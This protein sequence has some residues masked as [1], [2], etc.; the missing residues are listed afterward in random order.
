MPIL[1]NFRLFFIRR[2]GFRLTEDV[3]QTAKVAKVLLLLNAGK[4][5]ELKGKNLAEIQIED[6]ALD[7]EPN[8]ENDDIINKN[9]R[10][11]GEFDTIQQMIDTIEVNE[12][13]TN[14][15]TPGTSKTTI[16]DDLESPTEEV[17]PKNLPVKNKTSNRVRWLTKEKNAVL[18]Y[19]ARHVK[20]KI[21]PKKQECLEFV[22]QS[23]N[24]FN[25]TDWVRIKTLVFNTYRNQD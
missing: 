7:I 25:K 13:K 8:E 16:A 15:E 14:E 17:E 22:R 6:D 10:N 4:G 1:I 24:S 18:K 21:A 20:N 3:Y 11:H 23:S 9:K 5:S 19:F 12:T 2:F